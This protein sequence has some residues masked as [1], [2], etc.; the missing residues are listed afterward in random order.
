MKKFLFLFMFTFG[1]LVAC[2]TIDETHDECN[3]PNAEKRISYFLTQNFPD[4]ELEIMR[5]LSRELS[6]GENRSMS[7][8]SKSA[9][10]LAVIIPE[11]DFLIMFNT[12]KNYQYSGAYIGTTKVSPKIYDGLEYAKIGQKKD[13]GD[14]PCTCKWLCS[15]AGTNCT[16][17]ED[18]CGFL[19]MYPC[20]GEGIA[21]PNGGAVIA[22]KAKNLGKVG[23]ASKR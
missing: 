5:D 17:S 9:K 10:E 13:P 22:V 21:N 20:T 4:K 7:K 23:A 19:W 16:A 14:L 15:T 1:A 6:K 18:G 11:T 8:V 2:N 12:M 3:L